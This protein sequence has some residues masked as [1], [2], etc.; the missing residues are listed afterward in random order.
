[1]ELGSEEEDGEECGRYNGGEEWVA[2]AIAIF[3]S[4][5]TSSLMHKNL[6]Y[7]VKVFSKLPTVPQLMNLEMITTNDE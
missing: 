3:Y 7:K 2:G 1:M 6:L 4:M 5:R